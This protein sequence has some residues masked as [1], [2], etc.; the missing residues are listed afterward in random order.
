M[1]ALQG[2]PSLMTV[3]D[4]SLK[5]EFMT[6]FTQRSNPKRRENVFIRLSMVENL[7]IYNKSE[8]QKTA[9]FENFL[10]K[11]DNSVQ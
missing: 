8:Q 10:K 6:H 5:S 11:A 7:G 1:F 3:S 2:S 4:S 9:F